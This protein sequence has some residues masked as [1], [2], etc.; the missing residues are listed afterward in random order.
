M[1][2]PSSRKFKRCRPPAAKGKHNQLLGEFSACYCGCRSSFSGSRRSPA[3]PTPGQRAA[4]QPGRPRARRNA[5]RRRGTAPSPRSLPLRQRLC[6]RRGG[7]GG[8]H[9]THD[10]TRPPAARSP[11]GQR[12]R[13]PPP[14]PRVQPARAARALGRSSRVRGVVTRPP[15]RW[16]SPHGSRAAPLAPRPRRRR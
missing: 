8:K 3:P 7:G 11:S 2:S 1:L 12:Q 10:T 5:A 15:R 9:T 6:D 14:P 13:R 4:G 16:C